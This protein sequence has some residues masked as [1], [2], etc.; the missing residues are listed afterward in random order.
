M[1]NFA[2]VWPKFSF[3]KCCCVS[4]GFSKGKELVC[5]ELKNSV[6]QV[7]LKPSEIEKTLITLTQ[8][9][10]SSLSDT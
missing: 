3:S 9:S 6:A 10:S 2:T 7:G 8:E 4:V 5:D 1:L